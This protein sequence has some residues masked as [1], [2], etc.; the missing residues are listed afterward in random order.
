MQN[1]SLRLAI[2][3]LVYALFVAASCM[4]SNAHADE[5]KITV[6]L[7]GT[8][9]PPV[10]AKQFGMSTLIEA[11]G[12]A[13]L[14]DCGRGCGTRLMQARPK[15]YNR[16]NHLF[17][18]HMHSDHMVG[19]PEIYMNGWLLG[20]REPFFAFGPKGTHHFMHGIRSA[21]EPDVHTRTVLER[22]PTNTSGLMLKVQENKEESGVV[23]DKDGVK[24]TAFLVDHAAA[25]PA[26]GYRL[27]YEGLS[28]ML[29]GDT[30][31]TENLFVYGAGADLI[32]H[33]VIPPALIERL[34]QLYPPEQVQTIVDHHTKAADVGRVLAATKPRLAAF[35]HYLSTPE[36]DPALLAETG[37]LWK[38][39]LVAGADLMRIEIGGAAISVCPQGDTCKDYTNN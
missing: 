35:S 36:S 19:V 34:N 17:L 30:R 27:D 4:A 14:F 10:N 2:G 25:K 11:G 24:I 15:V 12:K 22:F 37:K 8:G 13:F 16:I 6:T 39:P 33:E 9:T 26:Y 5:K 38:G 23:Y 1:T 18:T 20:R 7:L 28:V 32:V 31:L 29:S 3:R 21:F